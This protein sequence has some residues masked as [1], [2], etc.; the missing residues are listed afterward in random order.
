MGGPLIAIN[1]QVVCP[2]GQSWV[3]VGVAESR[4]DLG[5]FTKKDISLKNG[6]VLQSFVSIDGNPKRVSPP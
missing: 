4:E 6:N 5:M 1:S 2:D 3:Q